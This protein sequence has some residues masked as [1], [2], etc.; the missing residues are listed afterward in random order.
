MKKQIALLL[1][2]ILLVSAVFSGCGAASLEGKWT[3]TI[4]MAD[5]MNEMMGANMELETN[6]KNL[7][8][9][10][11][12]EFNEDGTYSLTLTQESVE[13]MAEELLDQ[14]M[15]L[16]SEMMEEM[17]GMS[18]DDILSMSG[19]TMEE[20][21]EEMRKEYANSLDLDDMNIE[22]NY[23][24]EDGLLYMTDNFEEDFDEGTANPYKISGNKLT[25]EAGEGD[26][27]VAFM[28]PLV[29]KKG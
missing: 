21:E 1:C 15:P 12:M 8:V 22:G 27:D 2:L 20:F 5:M 3:G 11:V 17:F 14:L 4:D 24:T 6:F 16:L 9:D 13:K 25:I 28:F 7:S 10:I 23:K 18:M 19:M 29:L 26:T